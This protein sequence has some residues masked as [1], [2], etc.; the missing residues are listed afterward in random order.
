MVWIL[1][2]ENGFDGDQLK[3]F[4][5]KIAALGHADKNHEDMVIATK[6]F[7]VFYITDETRN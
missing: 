1:Q 6:S 5:N 7:S 3:I 2:W 4:M